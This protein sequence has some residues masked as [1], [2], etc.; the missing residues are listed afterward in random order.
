MP[1]NEKDLETIDQEARAKAKLNEGSAWMSI[2]S[3]VSRIIGVLYIIPW[4]RWIGDPH[5]GTQANA[6]Y[7]IGYN[8]YLI[9]LSVAIAGVPAAISKQMTN[10]MARGEYGTSR[11]L[12]KSGAILMT[13]TGL[14]CALLLYL[15]APALSQNLPA[16]REED[17][18]LV[19]RSLVPA[20][21]V[22]PL[23]S[24][25]RGGFQAYLEMK[26]SAISQ[27]TEQIARVAYMLVAVFVIRQ[28]L[29]GSVA[30][31][32]GHST[33]AAFIGAVVAI[34]TLVFYYI[35]DKDQYQLP[36]G[37]VDTNTVSTKSLLFEIVRVAIPFVITG[38]IVEVINLIDMNTY[39]PMMQQ[40]SD[41]PHDQLV[42]QY[43]VF[44]ANARRVIQ[45]ILS[46][47]TAIASTS[48]PVVTDTYIRELTHYRRAK[49]TQKVKA[50]FTKTREVILHTL[51]LFSLIM[52]PASLGMALVAGP[53]YQ[54]LYGIYDPLG[55]W[56]LQISSV[57]AIP[58]GLFSVLVMVLQ[59]MDEQK[60]A[61]VGI[62]LGVVMKL[63][64]QYPLL[65]VFGSEGAMYASIL[66]FVYMCA[67]YLVIIQSQ[68]QLGVKAVLNRLSGALKA[69]GLMLL[70]DGL[71]LVFFKVVIGAP[72]RLGALVELLVLGSVG[73]FVYV[74]S[75]SKSR[76]LDVIIGQRQ[77]ERLRNFF[78]I[79]WK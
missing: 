17:V 37:Y 24:I 73:A 67:Y 30:A 16:A 4:M 31:A 77:A 44:N 46:F 34:I 2:S 54:L 49:L 65:A 13:I 27:V 63:I 28:L 71:L 23:L 60:R 66:A 32:V 11:R 53:V 68:V 57:M 8:Y 79:G 45:I 51:N 70:I 59:A 19:I 3:M 25:L 75:I 18:V 12:F 69:S 47:A 35:R 78:H 56:Y 61:M 29:D 6:L 43:G 62:A 52:L 1:K 5:T 64:V 42:Y 72:N 22:I 55:E 48:V 50:S 58:M 15:A 74:L 40:V 39:M 38:S 41:L 14:V 9:F 76:Q 33:F 26:Q 21:A 36:E 20:L 7:S 10:Y